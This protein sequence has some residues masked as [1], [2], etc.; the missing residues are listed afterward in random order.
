[1]ASYSYDCRGR[2]ISK[3]ISGVTTKYCHDGVRVIGEYDGSNT[4]LSKFV[5]GPGIDEPICM[6]DKAD[7]KT[8]YFYHFDGLV[9]IGIVNS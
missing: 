5:Y 6:I 4:L 2:C 9:Y 1:V 7:G 3:T 8:V